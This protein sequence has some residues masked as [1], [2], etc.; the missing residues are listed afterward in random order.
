[1]LLPLPKTENRKPEVNM[2]DQPTDQS[3]PQPAPVAPKPAPQP[4][5]APPSPR[6]DL[7][8][9]VERWWQD[10]FPSSPVSRDTAAW[11]RS[12]QAKE[13]LKKRLSA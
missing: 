2:T 13:D 5:P 7:T 10:W 4:A 11:N 1:L 9:L 6:D 12:L 8:L 3:T